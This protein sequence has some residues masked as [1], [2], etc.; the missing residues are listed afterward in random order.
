M[1]LACVT[2]ALQSDDSPDPV[3]QPDEGEFIEKR[4]VKLSN[5]YEE[6]KRLQKEEK[7]SVDA[8][9]SHF[10]WGLKLTK[11]VA[12]AGSKGLGKQK[13]SL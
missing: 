6:L 7:Y 13:G 1:K 11:M 3:A 9:L 5:L 8:R 2:I 4:L 12:D 10:A